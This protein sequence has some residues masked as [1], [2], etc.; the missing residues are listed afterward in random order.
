MTQLPCDWFVD[1]LLERPPHEA[2]AAALALAE[3]GMSPRD[4]YLEVLGPALEE[5]GLRWQAGRASVAQEHLATELVISIMA[6]LSRRLERSP[7]AARRAILAGT[8][9]ELHAVGLR[10]VGDFLEADGWEVVYLG[11]LMPV[12]D[13]ER[14]VREMEPDVVA[15][16]TTLTTHLGATRKIIAAL[17][18]LAVP[19]FVLVGGRAY[20][21]D[22]AVALR[23]GADAFASDAGDAS[24]ILR[25]NFDSK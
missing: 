17:K 6:M 13:L 15:L 18:H 1:L 12:D 25:E 14:F 11:G 16:T 8:E 9:G 20:C 23:I 19:P 3:K 21:G 24:R 22:A 10:M 5:V 4:V 2:R 7:I